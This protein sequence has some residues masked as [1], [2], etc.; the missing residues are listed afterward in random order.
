MQHLQP[1]YCVLQD[2]IARPDQ[3]SSILT[4]MFQVTMVHAQQDTGAKREHPILTP[5]HAHLE[6]T[7]L[8]REQ[9][10]KTSALN[11]HQDISVSLP[12]SLSQ[13]GSVPQESNAMMDL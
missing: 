6:P 3:L 9:P 7:T 4:L 1:M 12:V 5:I 8:R 13:Q 11:V 2:S 10:R